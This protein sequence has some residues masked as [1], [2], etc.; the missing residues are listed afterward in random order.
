[1]ASARIEEIIKRAEVCALSRRMP[2]HAE[3]LAAEVAQLDPHS[4]AA[5]RAAVIQRGLH[6]RMARRA[7]QVAPS[8]LK[9]ATRII[10]SMIVIVGRQNT[11][12]ALQAAD[13]IDFLA[14]CIRRFATKKANRFK[15][16]GELC[17]HL[18]QVFG[19]NHLV[20]ELATIVEGSHRAL[21]IV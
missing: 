1:M 2:A 17:E 4:A 8:S 12:Q 16:A 20:L 21:A 7:C 6:E 15:A 14:T 19:E 5:L 18:R 9:G 3:R 13:Y 11:L 10:D